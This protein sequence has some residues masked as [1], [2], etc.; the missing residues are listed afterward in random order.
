MGLWA[1]FTNFLPKR[2]RDNDNIFKLL[3]VLVSLIFLPFVRAQQNG[4]I[5]VYPSS[6]NYA[7]GTLAVATA[8]GYMIAGYGNHYF[9]ENTDAEGNPVS[10]KFIDKNISINQP[11]TTRFSS[12]VIQTK[13]YGFLFIDGDSTYDGIKYG[14]SLIKTSSSG[15]LLWRKN[16]DQSISYTMFNML[17]SRDGSVYVSVQYDSADAALFKI[18]ED[19]NVIWGKD[20]HFY[21]MTI[22]GMQIQE[23]SDGRALLAGLFDIKIL[24]IDGGILNEI[25]LPAIAVS[26]ILITS[27][28][29]IVAASSNARLVKMDKSGNVLWTQDS[30]IPLYRIF[31]TSDG[32][33]AG[34]LPDLPESHILKFSSSGNTIWHKE[35]QTYIQYTGQA[36]DNGFMMAGYV[37]YYNLP[38]AEIGRVMPVMIK[39]DTEGSYTSAALVFPKTSLNASRDY[40][41]QWLVSNV[42]YIDIDLSTDKGST[43]KELV[44]SLSA[45]E[46]DFIWTAPFDL[47]DNCLL[48]IQDSNDPLIS[49][50]SDSIFSI[51]PPFNPYD[52]VSINEV[53]MWIGNNGYGSHNPYT[54]GPGF[55][56]PGGEDSAIGAVFQDGLVW[57]GKVNGEIRTGGSTY[58]SGLQPGYI[59]PDGTPADSGALSSQVWKIRKNWQDL[60]QGTGR[61]QYEFNYNHWPV[62]TGIPWLDA[63][64]DGDYTPGIDRPVIYGDEM[65]F[66]AANDF[67]T[68]TARYLYGSDPMGIEM[69]CI[70]FAKDT[71]TALKDAVFKKYKV[72]NKGN[73]TITDM[74]LSYWTDDDMGDANDDYIGVDTSLNLGY[75][76]NATN[77]DPV[78]GSP[79]PAIGHMII[80]GPRIAASSDD[81]A[82]FGNGWVK[83]YRNLEL[84]A[85]GA[86][87]KNA[88]AWPG[89]PSQGIY[90]GTI[91]LYNLIR[92]LYNDGSSFNNP[93]T[94]EP[95]RFALDGDPVTGIGWYEGDGWPG[96]HPQPGD[97]RFYITSGPF[98]L[99]PGDTQEI[100]IA[101][102]M[103]KGSTNIQSIAALREKV[104]V[105]LNYYNNEL[106]K[107]SKTPAITPLNDYYLEQNYPNPFNSST[108][109]EYRIPEK[110]NVTIKIYDILGR[111]V[112][113]LNQG[114]Q[115]PWHYKVNFN[116]LSLA[117]GVY[118]YR[119]TAGDF[120]QT[121]KM[122]LLK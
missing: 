33:I 71:S 117:S 16:I 102:F 104:P 35:F 122:I 47:S 64:S 12:P 101:I 63:N 28:D 5:Q 8:D 56:W 90:Q 46:R 85:F 14:L 76:W 109:I 21:P 106:V 43:W 105:L 54:D 55:F 87:F 86:N 51:I 23:F 2:L 44:R 93:F 26:S 119:I 110:S 67:D 30:G 1:F 121:K 78:Y 37:N 84:S 91:E 94:N 73:S 80:Q 68:T 62:E 66:N 13:D 29:G 61:D 114:E 3:P 17:E 111:E 116:A 20:F 31:E 18:D 65:L 49:D 45:E 74:Y 70:T 83:G 72:I 60:P 96:F 112:R 53:K 113:T 38:P 4:F 77:D 99:A 120:I 11:F 75:T 108:I 39:T 69:Q 7:Y 115:V 10:V 41:I 24:D 97:R 95:T 48:R 58:R 103:A 22:Y 57:G 27:D 100:G 118:F 34:L 59:L 40:S 107:E 15:T 88:L 98:N 79:P 6:E 25:H 9:I 50:Q 19:G 81:S 89:D 32:G 52:N 92:G 42:P 36:A 82:R